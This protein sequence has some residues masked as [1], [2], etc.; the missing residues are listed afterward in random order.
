MSLAV[1]PLRLSIRGLGN[2][3]NHKNSKLHLWSQKRS[4]TKPEIQ[5]WMEKAISSFVSQLCSELK[6]RGVAIST[7]PSV[8]YKIASCVPLDDSF[9][10]IREV[11]VSWQTASS[12]EDAGADIV[13][14]RVA[15]K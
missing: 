1:A 3:P 7:E 15:R 14:E 10:W 6:A 12:P 2:V 9:K 4:I 13:I 8:V 11:S 5:A